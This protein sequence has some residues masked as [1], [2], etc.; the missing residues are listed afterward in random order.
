MCAT[1]IFIAITI[2]ITPGSLG[3]TFMLNRHST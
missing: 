2:I 3:K 1:I